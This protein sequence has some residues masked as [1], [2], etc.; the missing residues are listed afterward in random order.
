[1]E[2]SWAIPDFSLSLKAL[3]SPN[4]TR[5]AQPTRPTCPEQSQ[6]GPKGPSSMKP[7]LTAQACGDLAFLCAMLS[8]GP[9]RHTPTHQR[10]VLQATVRSGVHCRHV[11]RYPLTHPETRV[12]LRAWHKVGAQK[13]GRAGK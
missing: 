7:S 12:G 5:K 13:T 4:S 2:G 10:V 8:A 3:L 11:F 1:M 9:I 6:R